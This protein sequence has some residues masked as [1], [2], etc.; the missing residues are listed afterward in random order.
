MIFSL[1]GL[2]VIRMSKESF[3]FFNYGAEILILI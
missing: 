1:C 3:L 2:K